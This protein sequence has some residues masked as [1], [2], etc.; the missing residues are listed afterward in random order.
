M[1]RTILNS[2]TTTVTGSE[3]IELSDVKQYLGIGS[4][5]H[6]PLLR[7]LLEGARE[8]VEKETKKALVATTVIADYESISEYIKLPITPLVSITTVVDENDI[9]VS[10]TITKGED[11]RMKLT[12]ITPITITYEAGYE[13]IPL[14][15]QLCV[16][17]KVCEDFEFRTGIKANNVDLLPN[18]WRKTAQRYRNT[19]L[20]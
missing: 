14:D 17:K 16:I 5:I 11:P 9:E 10:Y 7:T 20:M 18:N 12:T 13:K 4:D 2:V 8:E 6:D 3:L 19:W 15:L 1:T